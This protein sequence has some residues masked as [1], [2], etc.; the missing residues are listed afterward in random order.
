MIVCP[1][2]SAV[3][4]KVPGLHQEGEPYLRHNE[5]G[6]F[7]VCLKCEAHV[8]WQDASGADD[9]LDVGADPTVA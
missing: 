6:T 9:D 2:C 7:M 8:P 4:R 5:Q 3:L 1:N